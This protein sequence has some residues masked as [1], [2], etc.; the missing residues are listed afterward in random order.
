MLKCSDVN[1]ASQGKN[2]LLNKNIL[3]KKY[4][5]WAVLFRKKKMPVSMSNTIAGGQKCVIITSVVQAAE[6]YVAYFHANNNKYSNKLLLQISQYFVNSEYVVEDSYSCQIQV[7][8]KS[9]QH[10]NMHAIK[11][12][13]V[14]T[15]E[16][17]FCTQLLIAFQ[18]VFD[19]VDIQLLCWQEILEIPC[20][21]F[22]W[23]LCKEWCTGALLSWKN[24]GLPSSV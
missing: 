12:S 4:C 22:H 24:H 9:R 10:F 8:C 11:S 2:V 19:N 7:E 16:V 20:A 23:Q 18:N 21:L 5:N 3:R 1:L 14:L 6:C 13:W 17:S 15:F